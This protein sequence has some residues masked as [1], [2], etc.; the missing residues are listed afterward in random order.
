M[1]FGSL[2]HTPETCYTYV[3]LCKDKTFYCGITADIVNRMLQHS[4][5]PSYYMRHHRIHRV[6]FVH[7]SPDRR[8]AAKLEQSIKRY[9][10]RKYMLKQY[11]AARIPFPF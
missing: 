5:T 3:I 4:L 10:V 9:G 7:E 6:V 11:A 2:R 1:T 8:T